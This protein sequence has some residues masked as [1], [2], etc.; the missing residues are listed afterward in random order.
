M[1]HE[2]DEMSN[3]LYRFYDRAGRLLYI[4]VTCNPPQRFKD[5]GASKDWWSMVTNI[6]LE[7]F[8]SRT[9]LM[10]QERDAIELEHPCY[11]IVHQY[12]LPTGIHID[13]F[14]L[15]CLT[16]EKK[17]PYDIRYRPYRWQIVDG[18]YGDT[19]VGEYCC[20]IVSYHKWC[21][22]F[23]LDSETIQNLPVQFEIR[24]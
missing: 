12:R 18:D 21:W 20:G 6:K 11:N 16:C 23:V 9:A 15:P 1:T 3:I 4:G 2:E 13:L 7:S 5:H 14:E 19:L 24:R 8:D 17:R 10:Q 22:M